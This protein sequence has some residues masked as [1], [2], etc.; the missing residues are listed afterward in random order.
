[1]R[2]LIISA[3]R[4]APHPQETDMI[5]RRQ[6]R[7]PPSILDFDRNEVARFAVG[8]GPVESQVVHTAVAQ[9]CGG[10]SAVRRGPWRTPLGPAA[11]MAAST[12]STRSADRAPSSW[13]SSMYAKLG[14]IDARL[15]LTGISPRYHKRG[16]GRLHRTV[17]GK[18]LDVVM[19]SSDSTRILDA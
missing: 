11:P 12:R 16:T 2:P 4:A 1:M 6:P 5:T 15:I 8:A 10:C 17:N 19:T 9:P 3:F 7:P 14:I 13:R 18:L